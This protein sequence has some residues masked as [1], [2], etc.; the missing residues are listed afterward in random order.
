MRLGIIFSIA[1]LCAQLLSGCGG[2]SDSQIVSG[3]SDTRLDQNSMKSSTYQIG[4]E[5]NRVSLLSN[6]EYLKDM[7]IRRAALATVKVITAFNIGTGFYL[8]KVDGEHLIATNYHVFSNVLTCG[9]TTFAPLVRFTTGGLNG[10]CRRIIA[11]LP[12]ID[13]IIFSLEKT[14]A[15]E[16]GLKSIAPLRF[17]FDEEVMRGTPLLTIGHGKALNDDLLPVIEISSDCRVLSPDRVYKILQNPDP[18][19]H[20]KLEVWSFATGCDLS[21]GDSGSAVINRNSGS[22]LGLFWASPAPKPSAYQIS[23]Y[24]ARMEVQGSR[25]LWKNLSYAVPSVVIKDKL[26]RFI[27]DESELRFKRNIIRKLLE[28]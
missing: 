3:T 20:L 28:Q 23:D 11:D 10:I 7:Q 18:D 24:L 17:A 22:V 27:N 13:L 25:E 21:P 8:G 2:S 6:P 16:E 14:Q 15:L 9:I 5:W 12:E 1:I 4:S 26:I 19:D